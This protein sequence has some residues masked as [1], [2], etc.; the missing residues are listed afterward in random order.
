MV[1]NPNVSPFCSALASSLNIPAEELDVRNEDDFL[2]GSARYLYIV[3]PSSFIKGAYD[4]AQVKLLK[5][6]IASTKIAIKIGIPSRAVKKEIFE[7]NYGVTLVEYEALDVKNGLMLERNEDISGLDISF[8]LTYAQVIVDLLGREIDQDIDTSAMRPTTWQNNWENFIQEFYRPSADKVLNYISSSQPRDITLSLEKLEKYLSFFESV[9][10]PMLRL[11]ETP[12]KQFFVHKDLGPSQIYFQSRSNVSKGYLLLDFEYSTA[13][14]NRSLGEL[15]DLGNF[16][17]RLW[18]YPRLQQ[19]FLRGYLDLAGEE[20]EYRATLLKGAIIGFT[21]DLSSKALD[22]S[23]GQYE[24]A[25]A[26]LNSLDA[27][28]ELIENCGQSQLSSTK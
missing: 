1:K 15:I 25:V 14:N 17:G 28:I 23:S 26:L 2:S 16:Y 8:G 10:V 6:E 27:N 13:V 21:I 12:G 19:A 18:S 9:I 3:T 24:T 7:P 11:A 22:I 5:H 4:P 20:Y